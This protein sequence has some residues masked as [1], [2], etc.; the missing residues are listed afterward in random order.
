LCGETLRAQHGELSRQFQRALDLLRRLH[1]DMLL[2]ALAA[3]RRFLA[4]AQAAVHQR[5][6]ALR[7]QDLGARAAAEAQERLAR[8]FEPL[9]GEMDATAARLAEAD[10]QTAGTLA[11]IADRLRGQQVAKDLREA[12]AALRAL[13]PARARPAQERAWQ[14]LK[15]ERASWP[16][17]KPPG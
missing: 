12:A 13:A 17:C 4:Q 15:Q 9:P 5:G 7:L 6:A 11:Q 2:D 14:P 8:E 10:E 16:S 3:K 1:F